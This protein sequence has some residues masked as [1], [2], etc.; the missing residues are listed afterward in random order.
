MIIKS[1]IAML[2]ISN[3]E[4]N[5]ELNKEMLKKSQFIM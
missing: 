4:Q 1:R 5:P 2:T 3:Y